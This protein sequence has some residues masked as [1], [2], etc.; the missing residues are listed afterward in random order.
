[1]SIE[2]TKDVPIPAAREQRKKR[3]RK[4]DRQ[5]AICK[6]EVGESFY[7]P[8][9]LAAIGQLIWWMEAKYPERSFITEAENSG[10]RIWRTK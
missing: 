6:L 10:V 5:E 7:L 3:S 4:S 1:M 9:T 8:T 2:I